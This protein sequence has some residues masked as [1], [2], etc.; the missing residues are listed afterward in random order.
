[1]LDISTELQ[2]I[3]EDSLKGVSSSPP[4]PQ[5]YIPIFASLFKFRKICFQSIYVVHKYSH[6]FSF[7]PLTPKN[8][9]APS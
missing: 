2:V 6:L 4:S 1:M 9:S 8:S 5:K 3:D 7:F